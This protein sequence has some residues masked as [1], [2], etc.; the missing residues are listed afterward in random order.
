MTD[1]GCWSF[2]LLKPG[3][4]MTRQAVKKRIRVGVA[5]LGSKLVFSQSAAAR[6]CGRWLGSTF[7][8]YDYLYHSIF[9]EMGMIL[10]PSMSG[11]SE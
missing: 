2:P 3:F 9:S 7:V 10:L 1:I 11:N 5:R 6:Q 8:E 4:G